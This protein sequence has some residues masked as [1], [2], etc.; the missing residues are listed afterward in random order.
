MILSHSVIKYNPMRQNRLKISIIIEVAILFVIGI[1]LTGILTYVSESRMSDINV[2]KQT[3]QRSA[4]IADEAKLAITE[5]PAYEWLIRYWYD[6]PLL[7]NIEYDALFEDN[8]MT[9]EKCELFAERHPDLQLRYLTE[10]QCEALPEEDQKLYAEIAYSWLLTRINEIKKANNVD[11]LFCVVTEEPYSDQV[12]LFSGAEHGVYR[13]TGK[14]DAYILGK[15]VTVSQSQM[16]G[17]REAVENYNHLADANGWV[18]YYSLFG[19]FDEHK[20]L[21]GLTYNMT[22]LMAD[23][24]DQTVTSSRRAILNQIVLSLICLVFILLF[25]IFPLRNVQKYIHEYKNTKDSK[26]VIKGL[27]RTN[28]RNEIGQLA[29][30]VS[31][32]ALEIDYHVEK[33]ASITAEKERINTELS[34]ATKI[35]AAMLPNDFPPFPD[36]TEFDI[37]ASMDPAKEVG[38]DFYDFFLIDD[39]HLAL[40]M[41]DVS[42]KGIPAALF[43][44]ISKILIKNYVRSGLSPAKALETVN[45]QICS[46]NKEDMFVTVWLGELEISTGILKAANAGH[47][48][49]VLK[50]PGGRF[51]LI[52]DKHGPA[53]GAMG[54]IRYKE[55]ELQL[56]PGS[57]LFVYTDGVPEATDAENEF[58][59]TERMVTALNEKSD[60]AFP[61]Q[62]LG[63]VRRAVDN[64]V[65]DSEQFDDLTMMCFE[66]RGSSL[67][68][69]KELTVDADKQKLT[70]VL[71]FVDGELEAADCPV[72]IQT[73]ID[74][75]VEEIFVNIASYSYPDREDGKATIQVQMREDNSEVTITLIDDGMRYDPTAKADPDV[76]LP[77]SDRD[78]GG[79]GIF[80]TKKF[81]E[82]VIY[83]YSNGRNHLKLRKMLK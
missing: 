45:N 9:R 59:G 6:H 29:E 30:D 69:V 73:Q 51:E 71:A 31:E 68:R 13:G 15:S 42:G 33:T 41:A 60:A 21:I 47:E 81:M 4:Q 26:S 2:K 62:I 63:S 16:E 53:V 77:A 38:G 44:M 14:D 82:D 43:M 32:M 75:A 7:L 83:E 5:F 22:G 1:F 19:T 55:Y 39:D 17:M 78:I 58:F 11:Y 52:K 49:P 76:T 24:E 61:K 40:V 20:V 67:G 54:G 80:I 3:E 48:Y 12:F 35:Q 36:R 70:E 64:F 79:L 57:K 8:S 25:V 74:V 34:M 27:S 46:N 50:K 66:Y 28:L 72:K 37:Y 10:E 56:E 65:K 23:I 18:D